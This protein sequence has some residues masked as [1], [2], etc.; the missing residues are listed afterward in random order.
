MFSVF[1]WY[2]W[3]RAS[4]FIGNT[5]TIHNDDKHNLVST[6]P[7]SITVNIVVYIIALFYK[8]IHLQQ[9]K[10]WSY[11]MCYIAHEN[12]LGKTKMQKWKM[13]K[14][15]IKKHKIKIIKRDVAVIASQLNF[16]VEVYSLINF[17]SVGKRK[18]RSFVN[19]ECIS[20]TNALY[21]R[22]LFIKKFQ[23]HQVNK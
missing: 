10:K 14:H 20:S 17:Q 18:I 2:F 16:I 5:I 8:S 21:I 12:Y 13:Y 9:Q 15:T 22:V 6:W 11:S 1:L 3:G 19:C 4:Q 7:Y 23:V